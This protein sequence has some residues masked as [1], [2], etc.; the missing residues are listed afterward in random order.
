MPSCLRVAYLGS[1]A[2]LRAALTCLSEEKQTDWRPQPL[3]LHRCHSLQLLQHR[4]GL[5]PIWH[6]SRLAGF[7]LR[8]V[9]FLPPATPIHVALGTF[10][11]VVRERQD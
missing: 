10:L 4:I 6:I 2:M 5:E 9:A 3:Q 11:E 7:C 8:F 1:E